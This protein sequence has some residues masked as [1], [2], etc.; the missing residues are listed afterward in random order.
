M[1]WMK[2]FVVIGSPER[3]EGEEVHR[4]M[5]RKVTVA[6]PMGGDALMAAEAAKDPIIGV[7]ASCCP[8]DKGYAKS[9]TGVHFSSIV[10]DD[11]IWIKDN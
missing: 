1:A 6:I 2:Q 9:I 8:D 4:G 11:K 5:E 7:S 10:A 3:K